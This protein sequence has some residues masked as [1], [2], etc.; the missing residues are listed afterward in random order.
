MWGWCGRYGD[1]AYS[2][3]VPIRTVGA[4]NCLNLHMIV[5][6]CNAMDPML[7]ITGSLFVGTVLAFVLGFFP[8]PYGWLILAFLFLA[9]RGQ[10]KLNGSGRHKR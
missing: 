2:T 6:K 8:Y 1:G 4:G 9:R 10:L 3:D 7:L 5:L